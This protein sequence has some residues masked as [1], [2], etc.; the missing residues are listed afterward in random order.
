[1]AASINAL[2]DEHVGAVDDGVPGRGD[3]ADLDKDARGRLERCA[4]GGDDARVGPDVLLGREQ[5][6]GGRPVLL[7]DGKRRRLKGRHGLVAGDEGHADRQQ[8][9]R[10]RATKG[11]ARGDEVS[12]EL[13]YVRRVDAEVGCRRQEA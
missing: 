7:E 8:A 9:R 5:P 12:L 10:V 13:G 6:D 1:M 2:A 3:V 11:L 4:H